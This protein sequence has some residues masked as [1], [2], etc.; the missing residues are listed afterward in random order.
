VMQQ[1]GYIGDFEEIEDGRDKMFRVG[2]IGKIN[3]CRAIKPRIA[4]NRKEFEEFE[5][6][7]LPAKGMG[8]IIISTNEGV[9]T[10]E[11]ARGKKIGGRLVAFVY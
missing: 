11:E 4:I 8:T 10:V 7:F 5:K 2:L 1:K 9:T 3:N 6:Q